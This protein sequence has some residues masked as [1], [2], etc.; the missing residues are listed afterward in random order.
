MSDRVYSR[1]FNEWLA[2]QRD[3]VD[4]LECNQI[5][6]MWMAWQAQ[7]KARASQQGKIDSL[8]EFIRHGDADHQ[9]WL[10]A[11]IEKHFE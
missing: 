9:L 3:R 10:K 1:D 11:A 8:F 7:S 5:E 4:M 2:D 6:L